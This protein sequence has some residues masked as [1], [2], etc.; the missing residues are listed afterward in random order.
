MSIC[1]LRG[2]LAAAGLAT[3]AA[4][5][6][7]AA[8]ASADLAG[9]DDWGYYCPAEFQSCDGGYGSYGGGGG[10]GG[11]DYGGGGGGYGGGFE[12]AGG[13]S[14][15]GS[16]RF[17]INGMAWIRKGQCATRII[18]LGK[19]VDINQ[20]AAA[21]GFSIRAVCGSSSDPFGSGSWLWVG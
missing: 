6:L 5:A 19:A 3:I 16:R 21:N 7:A 10:Y 2:R 8:P 11:G 18:C 4:C 20:T 1:S 12:F 9:P 13:S 14:C 15:G 17:V